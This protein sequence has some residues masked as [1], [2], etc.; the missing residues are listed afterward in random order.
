MCALSTATPPCRFSTASAGIFPTAPAM[1]RSSGRPSSASAS[2]AATTASSSRSEG[3]EHHRDYQSPQPQRRLQVR[4]MR[5]LPVSATPRRSIKQIDDLDE[6]RTVHRLPGSFGSDK[7]ICSRQV[8]RR[9]VEGVHCSQPRFRRFDLSR[10][11][12]L[13]DL[14]KPIGSVEVLIVKG[15]LQAF[16]MEDSLRNQLQINVWASI[17][18]Q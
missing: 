5:S 4:I 17:Y 16:L 18:L 7:F 10:R 3:R 2:A 1:L 13:V 6:G 12:Y 15:L 14:S 9:Q 8:R 11:F